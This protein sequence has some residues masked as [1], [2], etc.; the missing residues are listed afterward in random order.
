MRYLM[1]TTYPP[2]RCGI[3]AYAF[4]MARKL[5]SWGNVVN[6]LSPKEGDGDFIEVIKSRFNL[7]HIL[8]YGLFYDKIIF[9]YHHAFFYDEPIKKNLWSIIATQLSFYLVFLIFRNRVEIIIHETP[10]RSL[11][12]L[13]YWLERIKW[14]LCPR[15]I[16]HTQSEIDIFESTYFKLPSNK[17][18]LQEHNKY[19]YKFRDISREEAKRELGISLDKI[20]FLCI[21]FI[22]PHKGFDR[23]IRAFSENDNRMELYIVGSLRERWGEYINYLEDLKKMAKGINNIHVIEEYLS[24][25]KFDTWIIASDI[26]VVPYKEIWSSGVLARAKLFG[27]PVIAANVGGLSEQT[28]GNDIVFEDDMELKCIFDLF[29]EE[30]SCNYDH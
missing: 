13:D 4:Q 11:I 17:Y 18:E 26:M 2:M 5:Q 7:L 23:T 30:T 16:F 9:Q 1:I 6:I 28:N 27:K 10:K 8:K 25:E 12:S 24:D 19:F 20:A 3:G 29:S 15:L 22:Q 14:H 21:G